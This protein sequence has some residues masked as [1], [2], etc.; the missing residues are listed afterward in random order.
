MVPWGLGLYTG[1]VRARAREA[2]L[3]IMEVEVVLDGDDYMGDK[4]KVRY[5]TGGTQ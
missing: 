1:W 4:Q 3:T 2:P 5:N